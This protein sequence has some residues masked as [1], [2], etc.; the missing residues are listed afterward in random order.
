[1]WFLSLWLEGRAGSTLGAGHPLRAICGGDV[2]EP[3]LLLAR[4][5]GGGLVG[6]DP[7]DERAEVAD[8][9]LVDAA[10]W[11]LL[12]SV[13]VHYFAGQYHAVVAA[14]CLAEG[15]HVDADQGPVGAVLL[16]GVDADDEDVVVSGNDEVG[17]AG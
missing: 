13:W 16:P 5:A 6:G 3:A 11:D 12:C 10:L 17:R 7:A 2:A 9:A 15:V 14:E 4:H 1:M 8:Q